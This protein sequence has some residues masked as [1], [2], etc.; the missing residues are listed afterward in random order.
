M[1]HNL[2]QQTMAYTGNTP[3]HGLGTHFDAPFTAEEAIEAARLGYEVRKEP[4]FRQVKDAEGNETLERVRSYATVN[5][6]TN[7]VL[8]VVGEGS[9]WGAYNAAIEWAD[10]AYPIRSTTDRTKSI[11][12]GA[13]NDFRQKAFD[14]ALDMMKGAKL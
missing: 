8:G 4:L 9:M 2:Y 11:L 5:G 1:G 6:D 10:Y 7:T 3:W 14:A 13:A 12:F